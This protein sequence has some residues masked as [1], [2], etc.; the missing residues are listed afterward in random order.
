MPIFVFLHPFLLQMT[1]Y[2]LKD[3]FKLVGSFQLIFF[4]H[5][6]WRIALNFLCWFRYVSRCYPIWYWITLTGERQDPDFVK[7]IQRPAF[8]A[9][10]CHLP[11]PCSIMKNDWTQIWWIAVWVTWVQ[12]LSNLQMHWRIEGT[13][14][15][16][17]VGI[18]HF[19][20]SLRALC[21]LLASRTKLSL[22]TVFNYYYYF[23]IY[24][25]PFITQ[26]LSEPKPNGAFCKC[27]FIWLV[28]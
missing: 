9:I 21:S 6:G 18:V 26:N 20:S 19:V 3:S 16:A 27:D 24:F 1:R 4:I 11:L 15:L 10:G 22:H 23:F 17:H 13:I 7:S 2:L 14:L 12:L 5:A 8:C 25:P 28:G